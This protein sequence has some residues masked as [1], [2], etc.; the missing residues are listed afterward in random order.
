MKELNAEQVSAMKAAQDAAAKSF[1]AYPGTRWQMQFQ[2]D[3]LQRTIGTSQA[4]GPDGLAW[5]E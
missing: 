1:W 5:G 4:I 2:A 3:W